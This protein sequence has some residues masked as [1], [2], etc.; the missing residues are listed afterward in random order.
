MEPTTN[1]TLSDDA[2]SQQ[3][4][5]GGS[6]RTRLVT[7]L[8]LTALASLVVG[9]IVGGLIGWQVEKNRAEDD[10]ANIRPI[11][12]ITA[13]SDDSFTIDLRTSSG[14][15]EFTVTD[16]TVIETAEGATAAD[17]TEGA[18][19]LVRSENSEGDLQAREVIVLPDTTSSGG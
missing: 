16:A 15:R 2:D 4:G 1:E 17:L 7:L 3:G 8:V 5:A 13:V 14:S 10:I 6:S 9:V 18:T 11:G 19:V 12:T